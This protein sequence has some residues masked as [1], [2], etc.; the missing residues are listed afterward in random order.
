MYLI[1]RPAAFILGALALLLAGCNAWETR[2]E[3]A[4]PE[5][6]WPTTM[7]SMA[8]RDDRPPPIAA[9]YCYRTLASVDCFSDAKPDRLTGY[10]GS[11]P[12]PYSLPQKP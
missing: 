1:R 12:D 5:S 2:S 7:P 9:E 8:G 11:Y 4:P 3:F 10:T 6:R